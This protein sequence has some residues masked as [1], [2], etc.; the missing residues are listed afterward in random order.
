M[1]I[2]SY[3]RFSQTEGYQFSVFRCVAKHVSVVEVACGVTSTY[4]YVSLQLT[5]KWVGFPAQIGGGYC[6]PFTLY[7]YL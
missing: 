7:T 4:M 2:L 1:R 3:C 6:V 5:T